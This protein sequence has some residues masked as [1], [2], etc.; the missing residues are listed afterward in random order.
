MPALFDY[1]FD[2]VIGH[3]GT[4]V[5]NPRDPGGETKYGITKRS[6][7]ALD[8]KNL[9]LPQAKAIYKRDFWDK[10]RGDELP[11][12]IALVAF[13]GAV[14]A[15]LRASSRW[16]QAALKVTVDG[17]IGP[18]T[19]AAAKSADADDVVVE[20]LAQRNLHNASLGTWPD[21][22]LGWSRRL[23]RLAF[24]ASGDL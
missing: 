7:P 21:F 15:G 5:N 16:L 17:T 6:Y 23:F 19:I 22:G 14:N 4:Y 24:Q 3:E 20:M 2:V 9:T 1:A 18:K 12:P 10:V 13:D 8:I 11:Y